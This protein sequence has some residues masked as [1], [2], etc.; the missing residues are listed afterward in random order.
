MDCGRDVVTNSRF[1]QFKGSGAA[2]DR[3]VGFHDDDGPACPRKG[4]CGG[5]AV[6]SSADNDGIGLSIWR[7][8]LSVRLVRSVGYAVWMSII[9]NP[10]G[11]P[12]EWMA[13]FGRIMPGDTFELWPDCADRAA[14]EFV[15]AWRMKRADLASFPSLR[16]ILSLGAGAEQWQN[17]GVPDVDVVRLADPAL[18]DEMATYALHWVIRLQRH[19]DVMAA[20]Q[21]AVK[22]EEVEYVQASNYRVG[23]L[24]Y[25]TIG[26]R[27][28]RAFTDLGYRVNAWSRS[29]SDDPSITSFRGLDELETFLATSDAVI[30]VLPNTPATRGLLDAERLAQFADGSVFINIGRGSVLSS[31][32]DL[33][34]ALDD[35]PLRT[36]VL[37]VTEP[38]PP[39]ADSPLYRHG[40]VHLTPHIAGSTQ[41]VTAARLIADNIGR[42]RVGERPF[43]LLDRSLG[44]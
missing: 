24:G 42:I 38:E 30:N 31:E 36:A 26:Q 14:V 7:H 43:P 9:V 39:T 11:R 18:S 33:V 13:E 35:G 16:A 5:E 21:E 23:I 17:D 44:Y 37:D 40:S 1:G 22:W 19:F 4:Y 27:V 34:A 2:T 12:D 10:W 25:G 15:V 20:G 8:V 41:V 3:R 28:G 29:G 32:A 6:W